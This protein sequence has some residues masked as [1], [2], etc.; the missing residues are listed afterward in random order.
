VSG[1]VRRGDGGRRVVGVLVALLVAL[2]APSALRAGLRAYKTS[3]AFASFGVAQDRHDVVRP[4]VGG[5]RR[6]YVPHNVPVGEAAIFWFGRVTVSENYTDVRLRTT[7]DS[8][9]V[10]L[11]IMDRRL[12]YNPNPSGRLDLVGRSF[13]LLAAGWCC[14]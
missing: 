11:A 5:E 9:L 14:R 7:D 6:V 12:W 2:T 3:Y 1:K 10:T 8:L 13:P 4:T